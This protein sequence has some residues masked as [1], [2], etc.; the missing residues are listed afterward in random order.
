M[1]KSIDCEVF[2]DQLETLKTGTLL[3]DG[4]EQLQRHAASCP[5]C[6]M[7]LRMHEQLEPESLKELERSVPDEYVDSMW[8]RVR[9]EIATRESTRG[10]IGRG[11]TASRWLVPTLA[12][13]SIALLVSTAFLLGE[14][15]RV[16]ASERALAR[17]VAEHDRRLADLELTSS[18]G[19]AAL[20]GLTGRTWERQ[21]ARRES[22][23]MGELRE[24]LGRV[25]PETTILGPTRLDLGEL[26]TW[27]ALGWRDALDEIDGEDGVQ[28]G[29]LLRALEKVDLG[30]DTRIPVDRLLAVTRSGG[31][32]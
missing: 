7:L 26:P 8:S 29:E 16:R 21:L 18:E 20:A 9:A 31:R 32:S 1:K 15:S 17:E 13:A 30:P 2:E 25:P 27:V 24:M 12:A 22:V 14:L 6:A 28:A 23:S 3:D 5:D 19:S 10:R 11:W 4:I